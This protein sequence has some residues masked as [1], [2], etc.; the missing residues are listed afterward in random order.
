MKKRKLKTLLTLLFV[1][2]TLTMMT[3]PI[4]AAQKKA[5]RITTEKKRTTGNKKRIPPS[6]PPAVSPIVIYSIWV[7]PIARMSIG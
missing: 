3:A 2:L 7:A 5:V 6:F 4:Q 1:V